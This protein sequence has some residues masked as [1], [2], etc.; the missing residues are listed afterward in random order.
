MSLNCPHTQLFTAST[1]GEVQLRLITTD[2]PRNMSSAGKHGVS[3]AQVVRPTSP[4]MFSTVQQLQLLAAH[5]WADAPVWGH[6]FTWEER[7]AGRATVAAARAAVRAG[8]ATERQSVTVE[9]KEAVHAHQQAGIAASA[10]NAAR[11]EAGREGVEVHVLQML[12][13]TCSPTGKW[14]F[15]AAYAAHKQQGGGMGQDSFYL[16]AG[17]L[18]DRQQH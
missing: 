2:Y 17:R 16:A 12:Q 5:I 9:R 8:C 10:T 14:S 18:R 11:V 7:S 15:K 13:A 6:E 1:E 4:T 3:L